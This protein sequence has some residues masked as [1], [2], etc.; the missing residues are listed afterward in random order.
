MRRPHRKTAASDEIGVTATNHVDPRRASHGTGNETGWS[1]CAVDLRYTAIVMTTPP[2][3][4]AEDALVRLR[5][6]NRRY[7]QGVR[8]VD[9]LLT[10]SRRD[11]ASQAPFAIVLGCSD[12]RAPAEIVF[13]Q[14]LGDLF[15]IRVAGNIV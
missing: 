8:S 10:H 14:G 9:S 12:S 6:G 13:D 11:M 7:A 3:L 2:L 5:E 4:S 1:I 15:V